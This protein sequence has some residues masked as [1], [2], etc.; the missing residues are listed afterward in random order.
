VKG[1]SFQDN[2][3]FSDRDLR[4]RVPVKQSRLFFFSRGKFSS[5]LETQSV[6][7]IESLYRNAGY[8]NVRVTP[9][10]ERDAGNV[11][12]SFKVYAGARDMVAS[13]V[14]DGNN[15]IPEV[16]LVPE[17]LNLQP[18]RPYSRELLRKDRDQ[19]MATY[20]RQGFLIA[21]FR[22]EVRLR[23]NEPHQVEVIYHVTEGPQVYTKVVEPLGAAR[24]HP[25]M[26]LRSVHIKTGQP[27]NATS[28]LLGESRLYSL[29]IFDWVS[30]DTRRPAGESSEGDVLVKV[31]EAKRNSV[32]YGVG[33]EVVDK[34]G[35]IP[36]GKVAVP[37]LPAVELP[38]TFQTSEEAIWG[39][40]G[41]IQYTLSNFRGNAESLTA[42]GFA[43]R[44]DVQASAA[45]NIPNLRN[46]SWT[47]NLSISGERDEQNPLY[48]ARLGTVIL[49]FQKFLDADKAKSLFLRYSYSRTTLSDLLIPELVLPQDRN[50]HLSG[51]SASF[52]RDTRDNPIDAHKG[53]YESIEA[54]F[55]PEALGSNTNFTRFLGQAAYYHRVFRD[56]TVW[57]NSIRLGMEFA[58]AGAY[59]PLNQSFFSGGGSTLRG[60]PLDGAGPQRA[61]AV[62]NNPAD[63]AT[64]SQIT[65]PVGGPQLVILNSELRFP[66][67][68]LSK[69]GGVVFYDGGNVY[70]SVG[71]HNFFGQYSNTVGVGLRYSTPVG[72]IRFDVGRNLNPVPGL[73]ATQFFFT[74]GQAF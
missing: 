41:S 53:I 20:L 59:I 70:P 13:L 44:L 55:Y 17:G 31:H 7:S 61:L 48:T 22:S 12:V 32:T 64:C 54:D 5:R 46:S 45:W 14:V 60:F 43:S 50:V 62:C 15:S 8:A 66:L 18:G 19:I 33:F 72:S 67:G 2:Q 28:L 47:T 23:D 11:R 24:T 73:N 1:V 38:S 6:T 9:D 40:T 74:L 51:I 37:G 26:I 34:G 3:E 29:G 57:A 25:Q 58:F 63:P 52:A 16:K 71:L 35:N 21:G 56:S 68:I 36:G 39:P 65:V 69:L 10:V 42:G 30:I 27:L 4:A 49:Q